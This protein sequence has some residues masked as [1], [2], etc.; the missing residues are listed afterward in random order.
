MEIDRSFR[1]MSKKSLKYKTFPV[2]FTKVA[3]PRMNVFVRPLPT[4]SKDWLA[5]SLSTLIVPSYVPLARRKEI[6]AVAAFVSFAVTA[7]LSVL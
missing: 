1:V 2:V 3:A 6:N 4:I 7:A 5:E